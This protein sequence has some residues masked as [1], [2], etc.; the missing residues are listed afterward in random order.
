LITVSEIFTVLRKERPDGLTDLLRSIHGSPV[1]I[2]VPIIVNIQAQILLIPDSHL[3]GI[4]SLKENT[5]YTSYLFH[6]QPPQTLAVASTPMYPYTLDV[7][8]AS[9]LPAEN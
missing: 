2:A 1:K 4:S 6:C 8:S 5:A 9:I 7:Q 3:I